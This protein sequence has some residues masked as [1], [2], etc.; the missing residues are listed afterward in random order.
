MASLI[1]IIWF[2]NDS[3]IKSQPRSTTTFVICKSFDCQILN[4]SLIL[5]YFGYMNL[6]EPYLL[7]HSLLF[8]H[9]FHQFI[10]F[11]DLQAQDFL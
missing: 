1:T 10:I 6:K 4:C 11:L 9:N 2:L 5:K 8:K 7:W 3:Q